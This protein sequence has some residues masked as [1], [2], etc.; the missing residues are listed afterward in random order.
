V[1]LPRPADV[2]RFIAHLRR[3]TRISAVRGLV[4][5]VRVSY[6]LKRNGVRSLLPQPSATLRLDPNRAREVAR[7][8]DLRRSVTLLRELERVGL[9]AALHIGVRTGPSG[10]QAHAWVQAADVVVND[11][12]AVVGS[13]VEIATGELERIA[14]ELR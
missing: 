6:T 12:P 2:G 14:L 5:G 9:E 8:V 1:A 7:A 13:Y 10:F 3:Q 11:D 4:D